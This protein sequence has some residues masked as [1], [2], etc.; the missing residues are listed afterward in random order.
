MYFRRFSSKPEEIWMCESVFIKSS[1]KR[2]EPIVVSPSYFSH[3]SVTKNKGMT[4]LKMSS[5]PVYGIW[6]VHGSNLQH[7]FTCC[8][9]ITCVPVKPVN[10]VW[11]I[12]MNIMISHFCNNL[13][14]FIATIHPAW[15]CEK[16]GLGILAAW[17]IKETLLCSLVVLQ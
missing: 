15:Q 1:Q 4:M 3:P 8:V 13:F 9:K 10:E 12:K 6:S 5:A 7:S 16:D 11:G 14:F 2:T 17:I